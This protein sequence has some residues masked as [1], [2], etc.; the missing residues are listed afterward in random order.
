MAACVPLTSHCLKNTED[1]EATMS[2]KSSSLQKKA[3]LSPIEN[4]EPKLTATAP[5]ESEDEDDSLDEILA[6][7]EEEDDD[8]DSRSNT[9][10]TS[11]EDS[12]ASRS[13]QS[14]DSSKSSAPRTISPKKSASSSPSKSNTD[15]LLIRLNQN[16]SNLKELR[17]D[18]STLKRHMASEIV[19]A[20]R[21]NFTLQKLE[22]DAADVPKGV[23][24]TLV[25]G[26]LEHSR[27]LI[28]INL[29]HASMGRDTTRIM[30]GGM[31]GNTVLRRLGMV[32]CQFLDDSALAVLCL[33][34]QHTQ[35]KHFAVESPKNRIN[36]DV[37][38]ASLSLMKLESLRLQNTGMTLEELT[39]LAANLET[40]PTLTG[41]DLSQTNIPK[42]GMKV[43]VGAIPKSKL[44][45][46]VFQD[47]GLE[48]KAIQILSK[49]LE[50]NKTLK[51]LVVS[52]NP[53][54][55]DKG[56]VALL[57]L[58]KQNKT[59]MELE[60]DDCQVH[61]AILSEIKDSLR[62]NNSFLKNILNS[63]IS[64]AILDSVQLMENIGG[65][66]F[67]SS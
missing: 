10:D 44:L 31:R 43:L 8:D 35:I 12:N 19:P 65:G 18:A 27:N 60:L 36:V 15:M 7:P 50:S 45:R 4:E 28:S 47:C 1:L 46:L 61:T 49:A 56:G 63:E 6:R 57:E 40:T 14:S 59:L 16:E 32:E 3:Q 66:T 30:A 33:G 21:N 9:S 42:E 62:Y 13:T 17:M 54:C 2:P 48:P 39:F 58:L 51:T 34:M 5:T 41:L 26:A 37:L 55:G 25:V 64:L 22:L 11:D 20:L 23:W 29:V 52:R 24:L 38:S 53:S 67:K